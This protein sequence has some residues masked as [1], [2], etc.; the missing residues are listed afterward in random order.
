LISVESNTM[1]SRFDQIIKNSERKSN[2]ELKPPRDLPIKQ[3]QQQQDE[4]SI[5]YN[6]ESKKIEEKSSR[7]DRIQYL[8]SLSLRVWSSQ[9]C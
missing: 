6:V 8:P 3:G 2:P 9:Q 7:S 5:S 4:K 1:I